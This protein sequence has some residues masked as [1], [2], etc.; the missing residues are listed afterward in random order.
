MLPKNSIPESVDAKEKR[1]HPRV[2]INVQVS[3]VS[4]NKDNFPLDQNK[5]YIKDVSQGGAAIEVDSNVLSDRVA[6]MFND[7]NNQAVGIL[8]KVTYSKKTSNTTYWIGVSFQAE[9]K[10]KIEFV[11][12]IVRFFHY[13]KRTIIA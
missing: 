9:D 4:I 3:C 5:G 2:S 8:G 13:C 12:N 7:N 10:E 11:S 6:I 1:K